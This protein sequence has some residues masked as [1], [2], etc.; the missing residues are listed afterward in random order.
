[1]TYKLIDTVEEVSKLALY[2]KDNPDIVFTDIESTGLD[3]FKD[4]IL[5]F[6]IMHR[7]E[8]Y[9]VDVRNLG[10]DALKYIVSL[11]KDS[12]CVF[13][14]AKFDIKFIYCKTHVLLKDVF[15]TMTCE[16]VLNAGRGKKLYSL[17]EL[18]EKYSG[19]YLDKDTRMDFVNFP[20]D[21]PFTESMLTYSAIDVKVLEEIYEEQLIRVREAK[22]EEIIDLEMSILPL[23]AKMEVEGISLDTKLWLEIEKEAINKR[24]SLYAT[25]KE[26]IARFLVNKKF[27]NGLELATKAC[28][29]VK[30]KK[31]ANLLEQLTDTESMFT[32]V[33]DN[34]N[35][36][37]SK[38]MVTI[39]NLMKIKVKDT[40]EKTLEDHKH[41]DVVKQLLDIREVNKQIDQ[42]GSNFL[43]NIHEVT[44]R[45]H[46][47]YFTVGT[48]TGRFSSSNPNLQNIPTHGRYR[49]CFIPDNDYLFAIVDYSQQE[50]R[51]AGAVS[52]DPVIINAY[53][54]GSDMHTAT[55]KIV[56]GKDEITKEERNRGKTVNFAILYG[57]TEY[58]LKRNLRIDLD[59]SRKIISAFWSGYP[60]LNTFMNMAGE[61]ILE[62]GFSSTPMGRRRYNVEK[63]MNMNSNE[64]IRWQERVLREG[65]N[66]I[67]QGGG[68][69]ILKLAMLKLW[70]E[71]PYGEYLRLVLQI[72]DE[73]VAQVHKSIAV[74]ALEYIKKVMKEVE[75][76]FLGEIPAEVDGKLSDRW[77]K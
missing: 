52:R 9:I 18:A 56:A 68:A 25:Y 60:K 59:E 47:E 31:L 45:I 62:L 69:D 61:K 12:K 34:V 35:I 44:G 53:K 27:K 36:R 42:Y 13:H 64:Y 71:N 30:T 55:G 21:T 58:G 11:L 65:K 16:T 75:Q 2:I 77:C 22:E 51:L 5:L 28:I 41:H 1:M 7:G 39:F 76:P 46:T 63:P 20:K 54:N 8:I 4:D 67:I 6:Q 57:S 24:E 32:W 40:N 72:H 49:E 26:T 23:V 37:S 17:S 10:Y 70:K 15:D 33:K 74:E 73:I 48:A 50:Y 19:A 29:P 66:H 38:Q 43:K 14:N 3:W